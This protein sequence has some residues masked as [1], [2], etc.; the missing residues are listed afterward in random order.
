MALKYLP[1]FKTTTLNVGG[2]IDASQTTGIIIQSVTGVDITKPGIICLSWSDPLD[3]DTAEWVSYTSIDGSNELQGVVRG[4]EGSTGRVHANNV[5]VAFPV[6]KA[7]IND[8]NDAML[9]EH[10]NDGEHT[11]DGWMPA[12]ETWT[13]ASA[14]DPTFTFTVAG[15]DLTSKY[16]AG[17]RVKLTQ[18][19]AKYF[20]I[21]KV[22]FATDTTVTI[23]GGTD[24][25]LANATITSPYYSTAKAPVGF[26]LEKEK[27]T[28]EATDTTNRTQGSPVQNTWYN[29]GSFTISVPI[30]AWN[31]YYSGGIQLNGSGTYVAQTTLSTANNTQSD[32]ELSVSSSMNVSSAIISWHTRGKELSV[33]SKTSYYFNYRT[34]SSGATVLYAGNADV[35]AIIRAVCAYL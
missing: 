6:S 1:Q 13:Y 4:A 23:Y 28:V 19:T 17:M 7:H 30:G 22:A 10:N 14:D 9:A 3:T 15:V 24:Y 32:S 27:W 2:G 16:S 29:L 21:T 5:A 8:L 33:A 26:P 31:L 25:D 12:E 34:T 20:I 18:S 35:P 11:W